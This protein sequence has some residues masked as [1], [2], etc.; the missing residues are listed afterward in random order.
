[1]SEQTI[2]G[3]QRSNIIISGAS[4]DEI[5]AGGGN[6][7][8]ISGAGDDTINGGAGCDIIISGSGDDTLNGGSG[9]DILIS[10]SG[11]DTVNGGSGNDILI[12]G[13][14]DDTVSGGS[15]ADL[16]IT[17]DGN[18][19]VSGGGGND[20]IDTGAGDDSASGGSGDDIISTGDGNDYAEGNGGND[21]II[22]GSGDDTALGNGGH[23][24]I[25]TGSGNDTIEG[26]GGNDIILSGSGNDVV[27]GGAGH[28]VILAGSGHDQVEG[29][30]G[31]DVI[32]GGYG[33]DTISG[34]EGNDWI[35]A[36]ADNDVVDGGTG[37]DYIDGGWGQDVALFS[38]NASD[39]QIVQISSCEYEVTHMATGDIDFVRNVEIFR[40]NDGDIDPSNPQINTP[41]TANNDVAINDEDTSVT[42]DVLANDSDLD[43]DS[44]TVT[45]ATAANGSVT[46]NA[47]GTLD[48]TPNANFNGTDTISY[49][50][51]D[52]NGGTA[53]ATVDVTVNAVND[54]PVAQDDAISTD[55]DTA[56]TIDVLANDSDLDGDS[57]TVS[58]AIAANGSVTINAD[59]TLEYTPNANFN[60]TDTIS[61]AISDGNGGTATAEVT[62]TVNAVNDGPVAQDDSVST[63]EDMVVTIDVLAN[64][65]DL[66][67]DSLSVTSASAENGSVTINADGMLDYTPN[68]N[69]N[70][71]DTISYSISDGNG[72]TATATVDVTVNAVNDG[73]VA[74]DDAISTDED[75]SVTIDVLANDSDLDGDTLS[76]TSASAANGSVTINAD[77][78]LDYTPN[79]NFNG[80]D[81]VTYEIADG[82]G[83]TATAEVTV[84]VNAVNDGPV[85]QD[86]AI[87]T[88][89][90]TV[91]TI[92][93]L[94]NDSDLDGD[95]LSVTAASATNGSVTINADGTLDYTPNVN[96][97]GTDTVTYEI[98]DGNG[99]TATATVDVTVN[100]V[101]D[102]P[103]AQDD[104]IS[105]DEDTSVTIDVLANDSDLDG[106]TLSVTSASAANG[107]VTINAD[108]TLDYTPNA[109][110][111]G[112]DTV[113]Y[114]IADGNGGTATAEV[115][116][117]VNAVNDGPVA[118]DDSVSTNEDESVTIDVL[119]ND[120]DLDGDALSVTA[121]SATNGSV[122]INADGTLEYTPNANFNGSDTISYEI[123]D[124]NGG[125]AT[126]EVTVTVNAVNDG[127][128]AQD[129]AV[130]T[131]EDT[132]V[133]ID[134]LANDSDLDGDTLSVTSASAANGSV[135]INADGTLDYTPNANFNGTDTISYSISDGNGGT[136]TAEVT[137][138]VNAVN[139]GPVAQD[140]AVETNED[141]A[142]TIDVLANDSD[143]DGDSL[144][145]SSATA[146]NGVVTIN[147][148]GTLDYT[149][150][151]NFNGTDTISYEISDGNGGTATAEVTVTVNAVNDGPVA[152][153][154]AVSTDEDMAVTIDVLANDSDLDGDSL[155]VSSA[156]AANGVVTINADGTLDYTPN[157]NF[158]G[159]D[160]VTYEIADGNGGTATA[161]VTVTV[162]AVN[163]GPVAQDDAISTDE[164]TAVTIDVLANDSDLDGD[165]LTVSS[166]TAANGVVTIN[167]D[168]T[169]DYTPNA[170]FNGTDTVTYEIAD[171]NGGTATATVDV[172]VNAV[173]DG[174]VAQDDA[175]ETNE[176]TAVTIDVL[177]NDSDLDGDSLTVTTATAANGSV[178]INADGTLDYTPNTNFN[179]S[180]TISY[181][182]SD[183]NGGTATAEV[184]V[185]VNAV[186][187]GPVAQ[188][189]SVSTDEDTS[190]T[191][192]VLAND[193]DLDGDSLTVTT[194]T[195]ANGSVTINA[196]GTLEYTPNANFN[197]TDTVTYE[198]ADGNGGTA[199][200]EV[201]VTVNAV[202]DG[203]VAQDDAITTDEDTVVT[204]DVLA[205][206]S[207]LD[208]DN[209]SV[210]S[211]SAENGSVTINAD[212][213]LDYTPNANF[214]GSDTISYAIS[215]GQGGTS[216]A[217]TI[218]DVIPVNDS[219]VVV[220]ETSSTNQETPITIDVLSNDS[221]IEG[222]ELYVQSAT[223]SNG[224]VVV[225][226]DGTVIYTPDVG[227]FGSDTITYSV[228]DGNGGV[229]LGSVEVT[230]IEGLP[231]NAPVA[232]DD[233][234]E[235][236]AGTESYVANVFF[237][238]EDGFVDERIVVNDTDA[239]GDSLSVVSVNG[240]ALVNGTV[241]VTG[242]N[243]G[244][245]TVLTNGR[246]Y[247]DA[248]TGFESL[249]PGETTET[250]V[251]YTITDGNGGYDTANVIVTV[252]GPFEDIAAEDDAYTVSE[253]QG[254]LSL[255]LLAN[256][257]DAVNGEAV[258][259]SA[260][261]G[262]ASGV[263]VAVAGSAGGVFTIN[264]N[265]S[266]SFDTNGDFA[267]L[268][269][270]ESAVSSVTYTIED[271]DGVTAT[272]TVNVT[273]NGSN[274]APEAADDSALVISGSNEVLPT[275][276]L[277]NDSDAEGQSLSVVEV[278][279]QPLVDGSISLSGSNGGTFTINA[280]GTVSFDASVDFVDL[281]G[282]D[283]VVTTVN[284][285]ISDGEGGTAEAT[286]SVTVEGRND[287]PNALADVASGDEES[288]LVIDVLG[289]DSDVNGD[290]LSVVSANA[291]NGVVS[292][293]ADGTLSYTPN[294]NYH[295]DDVINYTISDGVD[296]ASSTVT[297]T[298]N[299]VNDAPVAQ[300]DS[301]VANGTGLTQ[302]D[303]LGNDSDV[304]GDA[305]TVISA[306]AGT[307]TVSINADGTLTYEAAAPDAGSDTIT[308]EISD[309]T[310]TT[311]AMVNV[312]IDENGVGNNAPD[313]NDDLLEADAGTE[314]YVANVFFTYEDGFVDE[315]IVVNDTDADGD[316]LSVVSV[317]GEALV[318]G[319]VTVTGSNG[320]EF[321]VLTN[322]RVYLDATTGFESLAPG[323]TT[324]T[325]VSY[326]I[327][328]G[329]GGYD[330]ANV[331]VTVR[332]PFEDIAAED[333]AYTVSEDQ[334]VL[335]LDLLANDTDAVNGEAVTVSA[336]DGNAS[337]VG[338]AVAGSAGG[339]FTI[340][341][342]G[343]ASFDTN[344]DFAYLTDG[345]SAVSS[346]TYTI[347]DADGVTATA[348]VNVTI[349]GSN[350]AP[351]AAD[352]SAL[353]ISG[354]NEVLPTN[355]LTN[356]SDAE[357]QSL[358]VVEVD[359]QPLVDGSISLSGSNGGTFTINADGTVSFDAS[360]DF[361][362]LPGGDQVVTTVNYTISDGEGGTAE[363]TLSVTVEGRNDAPNALAD[364]AS[365]DE[366]STLVIDVL[367]ND[368]DV[369]GDTLSVVSA[370]ASNGVVSINADGTLSY[371][372]NA[373]YHGDDVINYTIS[374]GVDTASSTV[375]VTVNPVNDAPVAQDDSVVANGTGLTQIDVLGNDSD[376]DGDALTVI[377]ATAGTGTVSIN[378]DGTLTYEAA[379]PDAGSDTITY[380]ISDGT[381]TT[382]AMVNVS[383]DE[384]GVGNNA[385]DANDDLLEA[386]AG[387]ESY[388]A[389]V[390]FTY[391]DGFVDERIVVNDTDADGDSLS[392]VSVNG[393]ALVDGTVT[394]TGSNGG[395]F[396][397]LTNGR[398]YL[399]ATTGFE[400][401]A[402]GETTETSVSYTIT[403]GN[404]G[405]DT[406]NV[407]VTVNG[408]N[409]APGAVDDTAVVAADDQIT[410]TV[411]D[412]DSDADGDSIS[413]TSVDSS[414][415]VGTLVDNGDGT[416][417][418]DTNGQFDGLSD[419]ETVDEWFEYTIA[420]GQGGIDTAM[421]QLTITGGADVVTQQ[422]S[423]PEDFQDPMGDD[424]PI[425]NDFM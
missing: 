258:T 310:T 109:N 291:S 359:G 286:L 243:G 231:N 16:I 177:A 3:N 190:V 381:T 31:D 52:G 181:E 138:T 257:T 365:G 155:T 325:S 254:V 366:D 141:T 406:A 150:N 180:D 80:T 389:N 158:N 367:G 35:H 351:E 27:D 1:M 121:A 188:D 176:D 124:G 140:D 122:T 289:N 160:T 256:D 395:E 207:D 321:T 9:N 28:D 308:Y 409:D 363:A 2:N 118:Q 283:Q 234:L 373:N 194:A 264:A 75:T 131:N 73:P 301:V 403:D 293:N 260:V 415:L 142:V 147:A 378:A 66:D 164:D 6:D 269:D 149:P 76:V 368:S 145:V 17:E 226:G 161:E 387:T 360:V 397:V 259:V 253:D 189:D 319:T 70:G 282:G 165:S 344:G 277:T 348:T 7:L 217:S 146:A 65:S 130:E 200:A 116:V 318:N 46:I 208:G 68:A 112:T 47:D 236:E 244:E 307:G 44:L 184:T 242:S 210:T 205:N 81:T 361:V 92:D 216:T 336:V 104:A 13:S 380:E 39:Y 245:F 99:G 29:G 61:Y 418:Y 317:N 179:G 86:D 220:G 108:G 399:D 405:Y 299:P 375:T 202:N 103:V 379:A 11:D 402:P 88:D 288:T 285:T 263:G 93:V 315:R 401:L 233:L 197:G 377:S 250:S 272:A 332:G 170:N 178:T 275:N 287:A 423:T 345:E 42:I 123:S 37:S 166:A 268:T 219:P 211:A 193:S 420:D 349:N 34:D 58:S 110:F 313:A 105:T 97:N 126:A 355:L 22:T 215:D 113:T 134:V 128:V 67:G 64:D 296:T 198:I 376:V 191:I 295:G 55:E 59:G 390:F 172:T 374:D 408:V 62:V 281:P 174:P 273:I 357:G 127:P 309:G 49:S 63:D 21:T 342:N 300:D 292:I 398:V 20:N 199:T 187:D 100:A 338:V 393:E 328:D 346:V 228:N 383:I 314:S 148:D 203:P 304:D 305:L 354:S 419:G 255:D 320:G 72:G 74:Q 137:V 71:T 271:A 107:S 36:G 372:P 38:G 83:G 413:I 95:A 117:T 159:T 327:T 26:N 422:T 10:G 331:I 425:D 388:V 221:D 85:A 352:D 278:D 223:A 340:N 280:D 120:S 316:S 370:N 238:Y 89:E 78:T 302:I 416:L 241:T 335:S 412:N 421:V 227:Y 171:G 157:A 54:G 329:N 23:D 347:E 362:D 168:G 79:A 392:V 125:T 407:I 330:T 261:D 25:I 358:S 333:D 265:G 40:F 156:T 144:T 213:T 391:E 129:D 154:D 41:P 252:R 298:V 306:T 248:T 91:V 303:V 135:T 139:D 343:S 218:V 251:S 246:V 94:A 294:A 136:A 14:G 290:T 57:L 386:D 206:D 201:T 32:L 297:V 98:A 119:A 410:L 33:D 90:D 12:T 115:T 4:D 394:V 240:E 84:T 50:I 18:D 229:T 182:I 192:D 30:L 195:A 225:N 266:A 222:D 396:T 270:G 279:G 262:N 214:N 312:S 186:N 209:L 249:A 169:L 424:A 237:T 224:D 204:I 371:T 384:N 153:D 87:T 339:V 334:G 151:A 247:L 5:N 324:E 162:N 175:V 24:V 173:N 417:T 341:A 274:D 323:E 337:G 267:Y 167:A 364:V 411:L 284:Y 132:A 311:T 163:D 82:N 239:D 326:T 196:D 276:L 96:F 77:G 400:S 111:N 106:D 235:A 232:N 69:F 53:T 404:G 350:D 56:V 19:V 385:P 43:G 114:E 212:G 353:V 185:T 101:N 45:T 60:G 414:S 15:G 8:V 152:Q 143:L 382:T 322:G 356:D 102:G 369:N 230:V 133:T 51:S 183:G 48:Y